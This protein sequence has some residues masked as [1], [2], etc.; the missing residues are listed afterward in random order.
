MEIMCWPA[1]KAERRYAG[2]THIDVT[3]FDRAGAAAVQDKVA[4][5]GVAIS[6]LG[7]Y[8]NPLSPDPAE[9]ADVHRAHPQGDRGRRAARPAGGEHVRR[10]RLD[11]VRG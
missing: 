8:P 1:G 3:D 10:P 2:I 6:G 11:P 5:S 4:A 7:Y 9:A